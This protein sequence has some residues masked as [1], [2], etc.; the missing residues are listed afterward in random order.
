M[1][2]IADYYMMPCHAFRHAA[3]FITPRR[4]YAIVDILF[5]LFRHFDAFDYFAIIDDAIIFAFSMLMP[6]DML[7]MLS[8]LPSCHCL[9]IFFHDA[10]IDY[11]A[12][13]ML[14]P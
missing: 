14:P 13:F 5:R 10:D 7:K 3:I 12:Y 2:I 4:H 8:L 9:I 6:F 11:A 1:K